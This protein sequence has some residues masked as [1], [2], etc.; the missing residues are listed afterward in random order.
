MADVF[1]ASEIAELASIKTNSPYQHHS[2]CYPKS[3]GV[4]EKGLGIWK[5]ILRKSHEDLQDIR[6]YLMEYTS[7]RASLLSLSDFK[8][9]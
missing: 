3:N 2:T 4:A 6:E 8:Q 1:F 5:T 7:L 9:D